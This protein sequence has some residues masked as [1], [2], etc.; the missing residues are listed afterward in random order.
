MRGEKVGEEGDLIDVAAAGAA[1]GGL[2]LMPVNEEEHAGENDDP[3]EV[4][5]FWKQEEG[6]SP[7]GEHIENKIES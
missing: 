3:P 6:G 2:L 5:E 1:I 4:P 7:D